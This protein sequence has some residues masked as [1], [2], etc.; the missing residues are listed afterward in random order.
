M[1]VIVHGWLLHGR[2]FDKLPSERAIKTVTNIG[3][4]LFYFI[5]FLSFFLFFYSYNKQ[6]IML[7]LMS[8]DC[9]VNLRWGWQRVQVL[10]RR[11][12]TPSISAALWG[13]MA[14]N[15]SIITVL[16][17]R[18]HIVDVGLWK[19]LPPPPRDL[20]QQQQQPAK[21]SSS[22]SRNDVSIQV[23]SFFSNP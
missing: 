20:D 5:F 7:S 2:Q 13:P 22:R 8:I 19:G 10:S 17:N 6:S 16:N 15:Q 12:R 4:V 14:L 23:N 9:N 11:Q 1:D 21:R 3:V 18:C